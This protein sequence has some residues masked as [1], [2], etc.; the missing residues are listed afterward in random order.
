[1]A[2][3]VVI[4]AMFVW[5]PLLAFLAAPGPTTRH[6]AAFNGWLRAHGRVILTTALAVAGVLVA[7][8]GLAGLIR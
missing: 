1:M 6:L 7:A 2:V 4:D 5:L 8:D 3:V